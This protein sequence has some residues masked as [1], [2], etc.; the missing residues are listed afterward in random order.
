MTEMPDAVNQQQ[1]QPV[2]YWLGP[3]TKAVGFIYTSK[4][5]QQIKEIGYGSRV[6]VAFAQLFRLVEAYTSNKTA[7]LNGG[8]DSVVDLT[9]QIKE[10]RSSWYGVWKDTA[11]YF[12]GSGSFLKMG[13]LSLFFASSLTSP[14]T[15][16]FSMTG[17]LLLFKNS[18]AITKLADENA[19]Q[20]VENNHLAFS[21][22][23]GAT[24]GV[25]MLWTPGIITSL[26][27]FAASKGTA[28]VTG[29]LA[30]AYLARNEAL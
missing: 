9:E 25:L 10:V 18:T 4:A 11:G 3:V 8:G 27:Y 20:W 30:G 17:F 2:P 14:K 15:F 22:F 21:I 23:A 6:D 24:G 7:A 16:I 1:P 12:V 26:P 13:C 28:I 5:Y 19:L 29:F